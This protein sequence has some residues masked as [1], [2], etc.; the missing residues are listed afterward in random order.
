MFTPVFL[1]N[2]VTKECCI[3]DQNN[4][5]GG[6]HIALFSCNAMEEIDSFILNWTR[7][8]VALAIAK[9]NWFKSVHS[10][11]KERITKR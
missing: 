5:V 1:A 9:T 10:F 2:K 11:K 3:N 6:N 8:E 4:L 7:L